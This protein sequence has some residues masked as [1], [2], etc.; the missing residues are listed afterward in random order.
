[1]TEY[2]TELGA[3][4]EHTNPGVSSTILITGKVNL[5]NIDD[6]VVRIRLKGRTGGGT[7]TETAP[8]MADGTFEKTFIITVFDTYDIEV[9]SIDPQ[10]QAAINTVIY[11]KDLNVVSM[12]TVVVQ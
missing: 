2:I 9:E 8:I 3:G 5:Q 10:T 1:M 4:F 12:V 11:D 7:Q 6:T